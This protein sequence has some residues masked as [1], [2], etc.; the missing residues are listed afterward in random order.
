MP[1]V[2]M[3][4]TL[5]EAAAWLIRIT[6]DFA[7]SVVVLREAKNVKYGNFMEPGRSMEITVELAEGLT[8]TDQG[9]A[10]FKGKG[11]VDGTATVSA[12]LM[13]VRYNLRDRNPALNDTDARL[14][15]H[16]RGLHA[17]LAR[18]RGS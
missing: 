13:L 4:E 6:E 10:T 14:V 15:N 3:L 16:L 1:G 17:L 2:L 11:E 7:H 12:R 9:L 5:V 18:P 8:P